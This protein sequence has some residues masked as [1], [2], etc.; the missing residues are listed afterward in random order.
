[1]D[2]LTVLDLTSNANLTDVLTLPELSR[3]T[4]IVVSDESKEELS[5]DSI[6]A[7]SIALAL[8]LF[9]I[10]GIVAYKCYFEDI[11]KARK[12]RQRLDE[13]SELQSKSTGLKYLPAARKS[14]AIPIVMMKLMGMKS[15]RIT[16][17]LCKGGFGVVYEGAY[18]GRAV[19]V[20][21]ILV[22]QNKRDKLRLV[23]MFSKYFLY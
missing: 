17:Q 11:I 5:P 14:V 3:E 13:A 19:A 23:V 8:V 4:V 21:K 16:N 9:L 10:C 18:E 6:A 12:R 22:P 15:L 1:L 7:I 20:K 2:Q